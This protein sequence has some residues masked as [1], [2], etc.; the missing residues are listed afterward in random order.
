MR[1]YWNLQATR[2]KLVSIL[3]T[4]IP[5]VSVFFILRS[6]LLDQILENAL[7]DQSTILAAKGVYLTALTISALFG[8]F[9]LQKIDRERLFII[10]LV[11]RLW[12]IATILLFQSGSMIFIPCVW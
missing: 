4:I 9:Y 11:Y 5:P 2:R 3:L 10:I 1:K 7:A 12:A 8:G 6:V